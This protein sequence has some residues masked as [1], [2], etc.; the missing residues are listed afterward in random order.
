[1]TFRNL[2]DLQAQNLNETWR[3]VLFRTY[4]QDHQDDVPFTITS[5]THAP[6]W[7][8]DI[9]IEVPK[10]VD[11]RAYRHSVLKSTIDLRFQD[12]VY[13]D[14]YISVRP[15]V[16]KHDIDKGWEQTLEGEASQCDASVERGD[17]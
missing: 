6:G 12:P 15:R 3:D 2:N 9:L 10:K 5:L 4:A 17:S 8:R 11:V 13:D 14:E 7:K 1:M 16:R